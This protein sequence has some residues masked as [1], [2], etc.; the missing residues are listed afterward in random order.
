M[1]NLTFSGSPA[2]VPQTT[3][4]AIRRAAWAYGRK[5][6]PRK[7]SFKA[8]FDALQL[9]A[10]GVTPPPSTLHS[11]QTPLSQS[12]IGQRMLIVRPRAVGPLPV[13][14]FDS[15]HAAVKASRTMKKPL[16]IA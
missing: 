6:Q 13:D 2:G 1:R 4:C 5:L 10:C 11:T 12:E 8:L 9:D 14:T 3:D 7:Q 15:L 16:T